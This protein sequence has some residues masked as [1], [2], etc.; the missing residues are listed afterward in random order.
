MPR[1]EQNIVYLLGWLLLF[2]IE[3]KTFFGAGLVVFLFW[4]LNVDVLCSNAGGFLL[5]F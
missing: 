5:G 3:Q 2:G 4:M 1:T